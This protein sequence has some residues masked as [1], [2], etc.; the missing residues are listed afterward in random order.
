MT[1][2][3]ELG[4]T[5]DLLEDSADAFGGGGGITDRET[6]GTPDTPETTETSGTGDTPETPETP[7]T[8]EPG[9]DGFRFDEQWN[10]R[11]IHLPD[12]VLA[13]LDQAYKRLDVKW[14]A[15]HGEDLPKTAEYYPA[16][17]RVAL[18]HMDEV[19]D[20]LGLE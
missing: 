10:S 13:D 18:E 3:D 12:D 7:E 16:V 8:L 9:D 17:I 15:E 5:S 14:S 11:T 19:A 1:D 6:G 4:E 20:E 2:D